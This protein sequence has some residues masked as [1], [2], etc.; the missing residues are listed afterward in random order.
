LI[1]ALQE[2]MVQT[3]QILERTLTDY[4][5]D[6]STTAE[7]LA[8]FQAVENTYLSTFQALGGLG[9]I[10]GTVGLGI[11]LI[12]N[13]IE[14]RGELATLRAFGFQRTTLALLVLGENGFLL[15]LGIVIGGISAVTAVAPHLLAGASDVPWLSLTTTLVV[16]FLV[17]MLAS[18]AAVRAALRI[19]LLPA[20]KAE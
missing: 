4:G 12:R 16:V 5:F 9:L 3:A 8:A 6:S 18:S 19:P 20:L 17:G 10:L 15:V 2:Q 7:K 13:V 14:R 11:I 1:Q